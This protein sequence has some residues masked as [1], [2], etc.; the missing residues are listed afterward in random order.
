[1]AY[2]LQIVLLSKHDGSV[3]SISVNPSLISI[4]YQ[5]LKRVL[6]GEGIQVDSKTWLS[7]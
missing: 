6:F 5:N 2:I 3:W 4:C 1:M 7:E